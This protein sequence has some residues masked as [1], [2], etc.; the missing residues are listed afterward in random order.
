M[1]E[2]GGG[3]F[4]AP[5]AHQS[6]TAH[7]NRFAT[8]THG[9]NSIQQALGLLLAGELFSL[10]GLQKHRCVRMRACMHASMRCRSY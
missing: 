3:D 7:A 10:E 8:H 9:T 2:V 6:L 5:P 1:E 4:N